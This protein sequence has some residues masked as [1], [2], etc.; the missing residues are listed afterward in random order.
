MS[1]L[2]RAQSVYPIPPNRRSERF[3]FSGRVLRRI[4]GRG[5]PDSWEKIFRLILKVAIILLASLKS[6]KKIPQRSSTLRFII[7]MPIFF[8]NVLAGNWV[9]FNIFSTDLGSLRSKGFFYLFPDWSPVC[10]YKN[11]IDNL[12]FHI[13]NLYPGNS[14]PPAKGC[15]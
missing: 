1:T 12:I 11:S 6:K 5:E 8:Q 7:F 10:S 15:Y 9:I 14:L 13:A 2:P 4:Q 3:F